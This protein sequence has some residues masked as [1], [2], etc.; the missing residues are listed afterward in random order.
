M[1][2]VTGEKPVKWAK[3]GESMQ[4]AK[5]HGLSLLQQIFI[6]PQTGEEKV[7]TCFTKSEGLTTLALTGAGKILLIKEFC[8]AVDEV[9]FKGPAGVVKKDKHPFQTARDEVEEETGFVPG[10]VLETT[11]GFAPTWL[12]PRKSSSCFR[13]FIALDCQPTSQQK[14]DPDEGPVAVYEVTP[15]EFWELV[16]N[17]EIRA[18]ETIMAAFMA[19]WAGHI[20]FPEIRKLNP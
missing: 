3:K 20:P 1:Q 12:A 4:L 18:V 2:Q 16:V 6:H 10:V 9:T 5:A 19:A 14:L 7:F 15:E 8:Q 11:P 17:G 13:N